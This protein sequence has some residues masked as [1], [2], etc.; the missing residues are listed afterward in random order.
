[1]E[2]P[3]RKT[4]LSRIVTTSMP[5]L[6][7]GSALAAA[8]F[9]FEESFDDGVL[10]GASFVSGTWA[11]ESGA[12]HNLGSANLEYLLTPVKTTSS[13]AS[14]KVRLN[15]GWAAAGLLVRFVDHGHYYYA[16]LDTAAIGAPGPERSLALYKASQD[17]AEPDSLL[18]GILSG[19]VY[20][21][22]LAGT[23]FPAQLNTTYALSVAVLNDRLSVSVDGTEQFSVV[24]YDDAYTTESAVGLFSFKTVA[25]FDDFRVQGPR[26][27]SRP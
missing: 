23:S 27:G 5:L 22:L 21:H 16:V 1:M 15:G 7:A 26:T 12:L 8:L 9:S 14:I 18:S 11:V 4:R 17:Q 2:R 20:Y 24:D 19:S 3:Q 6:V 13:A 10:D 25:S